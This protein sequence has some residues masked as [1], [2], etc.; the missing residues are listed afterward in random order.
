MNRMVSFA[1]ALVALG[2]SAQEKV[3]DDKQAATRP[4]GSVSVIVIPAYPKL[5]KM[6]HDMRTIKTRLKV[7]GKRVEVIEIEGANKYFDEE[8]RAALK[9][10]VISEHQSPI[11]EFTV[12]FQ[13]ELMDQIPVEG[14][15]EIRMNDSKIL[16]IRKAVYSEPTVDKW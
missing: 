9:D 16:I 13:F 5:A 14:R 11:N 4:L 2:L 7:V 6:A 15:T 12:T 8:I 3:T 1:L 10:W